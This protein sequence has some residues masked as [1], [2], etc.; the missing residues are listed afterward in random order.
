[1]SRRN[2][3]CR[4]DAWARRLTDAE[5]TSVIERARI[6][7]AYMTYVR[8]RVGGSDSY[9]AACGFR[10]END[11]QLEKTRRLAGAR[12]LAR[13]PSGIVVR[14]LRSAQFDRPVRI[15]SFSDQLVSFRDCSK[16]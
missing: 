5:F 13:R 2:C 12:L 7:E 11:S 15:W 10:A 16:K 1:M 4:D 14:V 3:E 6:K 9:I 8:L